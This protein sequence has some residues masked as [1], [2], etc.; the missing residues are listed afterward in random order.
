[1]QVLVDVYGFDDI[2]QYS[3]YNSQQTEKA[4]VFMQASKGIV[5]ASA[6]GTR[7]VK[8]TLPPTKVKLNQY[9]V[10][11]TYLVRCS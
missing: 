3:L 1:M 2:G 4:T 9:Y 8:A 6:P 11:V 5:C 7:P 10:Y